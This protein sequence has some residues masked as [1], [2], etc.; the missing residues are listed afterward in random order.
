MAGTSDLADIGSSYKRDRFAFIS[1]HLD[2]LEASL[3]P[4]KSWPHRENNDD[5]LKT[6]RYRMR[7]GLV[8]LKMAIDDYA[9]FSDDVHRYMSS[10]Q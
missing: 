8:Q 6:F 3:D 10:L 4:H 2:Q 5:N 1:R 9:S 7:M